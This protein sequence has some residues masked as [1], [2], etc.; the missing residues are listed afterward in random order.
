MS[1]DNVRYLAIEGPIGVGKSSLVK[2][3][4]RDY[5]AKTIF[6]Q[7]DNNPFLGQFYEDPTRHAFQTQ[8]FFLLSRYQQ[9]VDL[10]QQDLFTDKV[11]CDYVFAKDLIFANLNL[12]EDEF[13]LYTQIF[14]MLDQRLPKPD[15]VIFLQASPDVLMD[16]VRMRSKEYEESVDADYLLKVSQAY[17]Q[18]FFQYDEAPVL[19]VNTSGLDFVNHAKDYELLKEELFYLLKSKQNKHYVTISPR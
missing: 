8:L 18:F 4:A 19:T 17:S 10:K 5:Q 15:A 12:T 14:R 2:L 1:M 11:I 3:L 13:L 9:Q 16:R 6:Q 7:P